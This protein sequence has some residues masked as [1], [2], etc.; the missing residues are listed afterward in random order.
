MKK[1]YIVIVLIITIIIGIAQVISNR[2]TLENKIV[3]D[4]PIES[5][6]IQ[7]ITEDTEDK[8]LITEKL[9]TDNMEQTKSEIKEELPL[10]KDSNVN[11]SNTNSVKQS[12]ENKK[13]VEEKNV[14]NNESNNEN[15]K[16]PTP[17]E[18]KKQEIWEQYGVS[19]YHYY[20]EPMYNWERVDFKTENE[21]LT[22]GDNYK[23]YINGEVTFNCRD[24]RS[25]S[26]NLLGYMFDP[27]KLQ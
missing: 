8:E 17:E 2:N 7:S 1:K 14:N 25:M 11:S 12:A 10:E 4:K 19:E 27:E 9:E 6:T 3:N 20:Y 18:P 24:V 21:C 23:P 16:L 13:T 5:D 26:G 22:F 15:I